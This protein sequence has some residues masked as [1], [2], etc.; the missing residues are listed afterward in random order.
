MI[1]GELGGAVR[2]SAAAAA[3]K[4]ARENENGEHGRERADAGVL[5]PRSGASWPAWSGQRRRAAIAADTRRAGSIGGRPLNGFVQF[6]QS[7]NAEPN[8]EF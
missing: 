3:R 8:D 6:I 5:K 2:C 1:S 4:E 7:R